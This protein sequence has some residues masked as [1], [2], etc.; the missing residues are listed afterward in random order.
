MSEIFSPSRKKAEAIEAGTI[1]NSNS[2]LSS[3]PPL[4]LDEDKKE[5]TEAIKQQLNIKDRI[6]NM[7]GQ[8]FVSSVVKS[9]SSV[10]DRAQS[11][12]KQSKEN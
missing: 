10:L 9:S 3:A 7:K 4:D 5:S 11:L 6:Q 8:A 12:V 2:T 1:S